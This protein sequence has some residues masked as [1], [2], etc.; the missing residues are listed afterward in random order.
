MYEHEN[1]NENE[2]TWR[3]CKI[4]LSLGMRW[5]GGVWEDGGEGVV[6]GPMLSWRQS[7]CVF[8]GWG[9]VNIM[10]IVLLYTFVCACY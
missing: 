8:Y 3:V 10:V 6:E 5:G 9:H 1:E 2:I 7:G 4:C